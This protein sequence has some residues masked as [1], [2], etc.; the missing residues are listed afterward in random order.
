MTLD[1]VLA[2]Q[3]DMVR[4]GSP[5]SAVGRYQFLRKTLRGLKEDMGLSG[6]EKF[7][8]E[9]QD[10]LASALVERRGGKK[11]VEGKIT[12]EEFLKNLSMEW[13]SLPKDSSGLSYYAG[14]GLNKALTSPSE[15]MQAIDSLIANEPS[16]GAFFSPEDVSKLGYGNIPAKDSRGED[17]LGKFMQ[18]NNNPLQ[19]SEV[20]LGTVEPTLANVVRRAMEISGRKFVVGS[21]K[22]DEELQK[23]AVEWGWSKTED[24]DHLHGG[25]VDLW[26]LDDNGQVTFDSD[27]YDE[28]SGAMKQAASE[29]GVNLEWGGDWKSF[30]DIPHFALK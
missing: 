25:A 28:I 26:A 5:S 4:G 3:D 30:K 11:F 8:P 22:R 24:S 21:G 29:L 10:R 2:F 14:D 19:N 17:Q 1:E 6:S 15:A 9:L 20:I 18:W 13:A 12:R 23:K 7:T 27:L 16:G